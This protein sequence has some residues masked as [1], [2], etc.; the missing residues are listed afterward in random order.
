MAIFGGK[1]WFRDNLAPYLTII[2]NQLCSIPPQ[3]HMPLPIE[4]TT[5]VVTHVELKGDYFHPDTTVYLAFVYGTVTN[6]TWNNF[7]SIEFDIFVGSDST[8]S[9][10]VTSCGNTTN[11]DVVATTSTWVDL[12]AGST[13]TWTETHDPGTTISYDAEG[14]I[15]N[16][17][18]WSNWYKFTSH[19][20]L[21]SV[22]KRVSFIVKHNGTA[23]MSGIMSN[24]QNEAST[25]QYYQAEIYSYYTGSTFWGFYGTNAA[26]GGVSSNQ[27]GGQPISTYPYYRFEFEN[28]GEVGAN[29]SLH[30]LA[31]LSNFDDTSHQLKLGTV[32]ANFTADGTT[33]YVAATTG[34]T[35][36]RMVAF[37][38]EDM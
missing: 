23:H 7:H 19:S 31:D 4:V 18:L 21:R 34:T 24:E 16:G 14:L 36:Q 13:D 1:Q 15:S 35:S 11:F 33:L 3:I 5:G 9:V 25:A 12:R 6:V 30:G 2:K 10:A 37:K 8:V 17:A 26:H 22:P 32:P 38:I 27:S 20:W 28:N 29:Y